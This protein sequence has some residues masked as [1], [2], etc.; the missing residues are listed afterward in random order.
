M[1][2]ARE[3]GDWN[4]NMERIEQLFIEMVKRR[5]DESKE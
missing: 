2:I 3:I 1:K 5:L 4:K